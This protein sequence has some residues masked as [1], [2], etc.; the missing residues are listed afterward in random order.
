[1]TVKKANTLFKCKSRSF[2][3]LIRRVPTGLGGKSSWQ[4]A[5]D[6]VGSGLE[7]K[8]LACVVGNSTPCQPASRL[9]GSPPAGLTEG[10]ALHT[11]ALFP[12]LLLKALV[13]GALDSFVDPHTLLLDHGNSPSAFWTTECL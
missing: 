9:R 13:P 3:F 10:R 7:A 5:P 11:P 1:M 6:P 12:A 8:T 4:A 2:V